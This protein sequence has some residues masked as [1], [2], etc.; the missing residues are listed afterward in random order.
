MQL[1]FIKETLDFISQK[2][3][4]TNHAKFLKSTTVF[5]AELFNVNNG[6]IDKYS[7]R[8]PNSVETVAF[9]GNGGFM[10]NQVYELA[11]TPCETIINKKLCA[12]P[13]NVQDVFP[14]DYFLAKMNVDN[15]LVH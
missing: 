15:Q 6:L 3:Y 1:K 12:Y 10:P 14:K 9:Y 5:L 4:E 8:K 13:A 7:I 11:N 2:G